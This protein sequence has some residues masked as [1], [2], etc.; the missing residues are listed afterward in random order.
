MLLFRNH[1]TTSTETAIK[2]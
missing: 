2:C 1:K